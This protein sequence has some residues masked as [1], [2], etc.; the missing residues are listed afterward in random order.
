MGKLNHKTKRNKAPPVWAMAALILAVCVIADVRCLA[1]E[2]PAWTRA[3]RQDHPRLFFNTQT[4][5]AVRERALGAERPWYLSIK[6]R[7]DRLAEAAG[8]KDRLEAREYGPEAA[9]SAFVYRTTRQERYINT[10]ARVGTL[11]L[12]LTYC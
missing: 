10:A 9:W 6:E 5:P 1:E 2:L 3:I 4:W 8:G 7:I 12:P 11:R